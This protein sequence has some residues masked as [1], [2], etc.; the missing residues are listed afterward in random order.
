MWL[1]L[2]TIKQRKELTIIAYYLVMAT[3]KEQNGLQVAAFLLNETFQRQRYFEKILRSDAD[4]K[5]FEQWIPL[6]PGLR[7]SIYDIDSLRLVQ[8][9]IRN[10]KVNPELITFFQH[11]KTVIG[12][13]EISIGEELQSY[14][15]TFIGDEQNVQH[16]AYNTIALLVALYSE[17]HSPIIATTKKNLA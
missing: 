6:K 3:Q 1:L 5:K 2:S 15:L 12:K 7:L 4:W 9:L 17:R 14:H 8:Q 11:Q 10:V 13:R 16:R